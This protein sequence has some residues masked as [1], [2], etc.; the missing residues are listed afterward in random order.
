VDLIE[1]V[2]KIFGLEGGDGLTCPGGTYSN[3][4]AMLC[5]RNTLFPHTKLEGV[6]K[7]D[8]L[9]VLTSAEAHYSISKSANTL[10]L[11]LQNVIKVP[12]NADGEMIP[13]ELERIFTEL[14]AAGR[15]PFFVNATSGTTVTGSFDPL[16]EIGR[17]AKE[18]GAW[19]H[20][21]GCW[22][23]SVIFSRRHAHLMKGTH[24]ADSLSWNP[25]KMLGVPLQMSLLITREK[26]LL[27]QS[28]GKSSP[29]DSAA[30]CGVIHSP[31]FF[32]LALGVTYLFRGGDYDL[33]D[34]TIQCGR[35]PDILKLF[36][37]WRYHG[38]EGFERRVDTAFDNV[39]RFVAL[40]K[41]RGDVFELAREP[42]GLNICFWY[43]PGWLRALSPGEERDALYTKVTAS[44]CNGVN[45]AARVLVDYSPNQRGPEFFRMVIN[46]PQIRE[47]DLELVLSEIERVG[48]PFVDELKRQRSGVRS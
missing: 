4:L 25:H 39:Q 3:M 8:R 14:K 40:L 9:V 26:G 18:H 7:E 6:S 32:S 33:G 24:L 30:N 13:E 22:G 23:G 47:S 37:T 36:L 17:I 21:D 5:A 34:K 38:R 42:C 44:T 2:A 10:G 11:G 28:N 20:V 48:S 1:E 46:S 41:A 27:Q 31:L 35:K 45:A 29:H 15:R 12:T 19:F 43:N 16:S